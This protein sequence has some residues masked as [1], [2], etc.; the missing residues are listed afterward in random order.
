MKNNGANWQ[1][2]GAK[3]DRMGLGKKS[4]WGYF[5]CIFIGSQWG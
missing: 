4:E 5:T 3:K 1:D 2:N